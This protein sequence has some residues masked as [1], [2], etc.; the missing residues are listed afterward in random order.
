M[1]IISRSWVRHLKVI[2]GEHLSLENESII[3][4]TAEELS[5]LVFSDLTV[6]LIEN[7]EYIN[8]DI[9]F[10][11]SDFIRGSVPMTKENIRLIS[12]GKL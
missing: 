9:P 11:D 7:Q 1:R 2:E 3:T 10:R 12:I 4:V 5:K 6:L 8:K